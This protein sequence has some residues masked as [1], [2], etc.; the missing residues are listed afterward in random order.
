M[1]A[2]TYGDGFNHPEDGDPLKCCSYELHRVS[3]YHMGFLGWDNLQ[4]VLN[5]DN[6]VF[7]ANYYS[8]TDDYFALIDKSAP[9][10]VGYNSGVK[11]TLEARF[12]TLTVLGLKYTNVYQMHYSPGFSRFQ[13]I[14][15]CPNIGF[16]KFEYQNLMNV[17]DTWELKKSH[18]VF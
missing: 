8:K 7:G 10:S 6:I 16:V 9:D 14:W 4:Y 12:D 2:Q 3:I 18:V 13:R 11:V 17:I 1:I 5:Y 15:W